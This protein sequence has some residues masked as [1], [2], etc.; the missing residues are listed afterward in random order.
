[1]LN[2][3]YL[4]G[5]T[6]E[7]DT[8]LGVATQLLGFI[9]E[10]T[11]LSFDSVDVL[12]QR[13]SSRSHLN[14]E[15][16]LQTWKC[17]AGTPSSLEAVAH[18]YRGAALILLY[19]KIRKDSEAHDDTWLGFD[20]SLETLKDKIE[21]VVT[22]VLEHIK[23]V[24][25]NHVS[26][27]PLLFPL[28]IVGGEVDYQKEMELVRKRLESSYRKR[29]FRNISRAL[30]VLEQLWIGRQVQGVLGGKRAEWEDILRSTEESL[31]LT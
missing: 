17:P 4:S 27:S 19:R 2:R 11:C 23:S 22:S 24:P 28:F 31:L 21:A 30:D 25:E 16:D 5:N 26:E 8:Y 1:L 3:G 6:E 9:A 12:M 10:I 15:R 18:A 7:F 14:I 29:S 20:I 13:Q